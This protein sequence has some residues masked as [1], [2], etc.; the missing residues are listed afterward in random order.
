MLLLVL[1]VVFLFF[2]LGSMAMDG[3]QDSN[4]K[5]IQQQRFNSMQ[6]IWKPQGLAK[7]QEISQEHEIS[8]RPGLEDLKNG[9]NK[10]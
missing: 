6:E 5:L 3:G 2:W 4:E 7:E 9:K 8:Q 10:F 1:N